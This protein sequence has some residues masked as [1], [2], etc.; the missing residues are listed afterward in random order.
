MQLLIFIAL[1][2][3]LSSCGVLHRFK[4]TE[5]IKKDTSYVYALPY[6]KGKAHLMI[7]GNNSWF[8]HKGR[9]GLDFKMKKGSAITAVRGGV[10]VRS[11]G[12]FTK[13]GLNKKYFRGANQIVI[14]HADGTIASYGHLQHKGALVAVGDTVV[15]GQLIGKSGSTGYSALPHLHFALY[16]TTP[17]GRKPLPLRFK[18][19][20]GIKYLRPG[21]WYR[22]Q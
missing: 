20:K 1:F 2:F 19:G 4:S 13:G 17:S 8:S 5:Q 18:T 11:E 9:L 7:Q 12:K 6:P 10:V 21:R 22:A 16:G 3:L 14:R 15:T